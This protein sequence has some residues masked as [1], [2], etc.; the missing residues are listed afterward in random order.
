MSFEKTS[1]EKDAI[2]AEKDKQIAQVQ[3]K[4]DDM[5]EQFKEMLQT[6]LEKLTEKIQTGG[7]W[8]EELLP[9]K[10]NLEDLGIH[11]SES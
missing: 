5:T 9:G 6:T 8:S 7:E 11:L 10:Q 3:G 4:I 2:L 1:A